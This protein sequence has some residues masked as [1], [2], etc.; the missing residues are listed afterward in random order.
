MCGAEPQGTFPGIA[1][2]AAYLH[3]HKQLSEEE[4]VIV[5]PIDPYVEDSYYAE[6][7]KLEGLVEAGA[8]VAATWLSRRMPVRI[9]VILCQKMMVRAAR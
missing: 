8:A 7:K 6:L 4:I 1:L 3:D 2:T 5:C 9:M